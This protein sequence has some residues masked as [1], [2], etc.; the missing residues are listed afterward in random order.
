V[1]RRTVRWFAGAGAIKGK[2]WEAGP[3]GRTRGRGLSGLLLRRFPA[4]AEGARP[5]GRYVS[6]ATGDSHTEISS[7]VTTGAITSA[8]CS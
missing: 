2:K 4:S 5:Y 6:F 8:S 3:V 1:R 7:N